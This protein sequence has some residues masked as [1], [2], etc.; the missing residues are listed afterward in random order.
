MKRNQIVKYDMKVVRS[1]VKRRPK[2]KFDIPFHIKDMLLVRLLDFL[3][4]L[5]RLLDLLMLLVRL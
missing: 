3:M 2:G 5:V 4:L 1:A